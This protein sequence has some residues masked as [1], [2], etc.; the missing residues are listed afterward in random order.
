MV[1]YFNLQGKKELFIY[2]VLNSFASGAS[3]WSVLQVTDRLGANANDVF[4][5][6]DCSK[7][8]AI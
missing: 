3:Q 1:I 2:V 6:M 4:W 8:L 5:Q 7:T